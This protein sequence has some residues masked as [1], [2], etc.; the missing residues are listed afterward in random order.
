MQTAILRLKNRN[1]RI[2]ISAVARETGVSAALLHNTYPDVAEQ[3]RALQGKA[4]RA[5]RDDLRIEVA[6]LRD[7]NAKLRAEKEIAEADAR[8]LASMLETLR[9]E[10]ARA[11]AV[12]TGKVVTLQR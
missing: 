11:A 12:G 10:L 4:S 3:I 9:H 8:R 2:T 1:E 5:Q 7:E 6:R